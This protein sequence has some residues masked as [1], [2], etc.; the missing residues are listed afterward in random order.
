MRDQS[1]AESGLGPISLAV[2]KA[3]A[4]EEAAALAAGKD[5]SLSPDISPSVLI[6]R[7]LDLE[8]DQRALKVEMKKTW[9]HSRDRE[10]TRIQLRSNTL[11]RRIDAWYSALQLYIPSTLLL[12]QKATTTKTI[13]PY[14]LSLW[15][16]SQIGTQAQVDR[17]LT[18][19]RIPATCGASARG[20]DDSKAGS[21]TP[22]YEAQIAVSRDEY[23]QARI[24]L[25]ALGKM[26]GK[27]GLEA[28]YLPL[29]DGDIRAMVRPELD[30]IGESRDPNDMTGATRRVSS[31]IWR[32]ASAAED[33]HTVYEAEAVKVEWAKSRA[34]ASRY[35]EEI[36]IVKEEMN[37]TLRFFKWKEAR[38]YEKAGARQA[39]EEVSEDYDEGLRAYAKR[40]GSICLTLRR[41]FEHAWQGVNGEIATAYAEIKE[42]ALFYNRTAKEREAGEVT[43][44]LPVEPTSDVEMS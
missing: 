43:G 29:E 7:G 24:A 27:K 26:L 3:L 21:S 41:R 38:W 1:S 2:R 25:L 34:R 4:D 12:R 5:V 17:R 19:H 10:L 32:H 14:D 11:I 42:P 22:H 35:Q 37:R 40:Q 33:N 20:S 18:G 44:F 36:R 31:W 23:R 28:F 8:A 9:T 16:P 6:S 13:P 15:L 39:V 30:D